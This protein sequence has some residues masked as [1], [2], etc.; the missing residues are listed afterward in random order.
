MKA[1]I[2]HQISMI[3]MALFLLVFVGGMLLYLFEK[4]GN[5]NISTYWDGVWLAAAT[6]SSVGYG[7]VYPVT[8]EGKVISSILGF[9]GLL[10]IGITSALFTTYIL[11]Y[12]GHLKR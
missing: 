5:E 9:S 2:K 10:L 4:T 6:A 11:R 1:K 12:R 3:V 7:D 8:A